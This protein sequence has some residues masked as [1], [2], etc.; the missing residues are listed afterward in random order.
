MR[1]TASFEVFLVMES[2]TNKKLLKRSPNSP[3]DALSVW[4]PLEQSP[5]RDGVVVFMA[6]CTRAAAG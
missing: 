1:R 3:P 2:D 4:G 5:G 6:A